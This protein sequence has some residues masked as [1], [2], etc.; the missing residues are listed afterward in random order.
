MIFIFLCFRFDTKENKKLTGSKIF[1]PKTNITTACSLVGSITVERS[2]SF[3]ASSPFL[4]RLIHYRSPPKEARNENFAYK[5]SSRSLRY[6][7]FHQESIVDASEDSQLRAAIAASLA[8]TTSA[9]QSDSSS[10]DDDEDFADLE[11]SE[12]DSDGEHSSPRKNNSKVNVT[13]EVK[14][15]KNFD[16]STNEA[17]ETYEKRGKESQNEHL[18]ANTS[19]TNKGSV[20]KRRKIE[21]SEAQISEGNSKVEDKGET[22]QRTQEQAGE[23]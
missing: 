18:K 6:I 9:K 16:D 13:T 8:C 19:L 3:F 21:K 23:W 2:N 15:D 12:S 10:D 17:Q 11:F 5:S 20:T 22:D 1:K 14:K 7:L 4:P